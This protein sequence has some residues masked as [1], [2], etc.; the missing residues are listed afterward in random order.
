L[1]VATRLALPLPLTGIVERSSAQ[2]SAHA[3]SAGWADPVTLLAIGFVS[4]ALLAGLAEHYQRLAFAHFA[5]RSV[6][7]ARAAALAGIG[8]T[9]G[10]GPADLAAE[11]IVDSA[12]VKQGLK[13]LLNHI[14]LN[15]LLVL[16]ACFA[17]ASVDTQ[18]GVV[19]FAGAGTVV[20]VAILGA[21][22]VAAVAAEHRH[23]EALLSRVIQR[24]ASGGRGEG[25]IDEL[26]E[27]R[28][29]DVAS[30]EADV[31]MTR[32]EGRT[33]CAVHVVLTLT[34]A[35]VLAV[36]VG[37]S[38]AGRLGNGGLFTVVAYL[39]LVYGP[40]VRLARQ[41]TRIG[42]L[43]VSAKRLGLVLLD[44]PRKNGGPRVTDPEGEPLPS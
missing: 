1:L 22:R 36:G 37:A 38:E 10:D 6:S 44:P 43:V 23:R 9:N 5:G 8:N 35:A 33:T 18:L 30:A 21:T 15:G 16:G 42:S 39:L 19:L 7:D 29:L 20:T 34:A 32:S 26:S 40:G 17:L 11:V 13:G 24:L 2:G 27:L 28:G 4:L 12:R 14:V 25:Y 41:I 3:V 31:N